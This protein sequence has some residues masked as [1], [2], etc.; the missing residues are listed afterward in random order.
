MVDLLGGQNLSLLIALTIL[1]ILI[2]SQNGKF[3]LPQNLLNIGQN[4]AV[5]GLVATVETVIIVAG[6]LDISVGA[7]AGVASVVC[8]LAVV[9]TG[10]P[11]AGIVAG[12]L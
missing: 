9:N 10:S 4:I 2:G 7:I 8:A 6:C 3:F 1:I 12:T 11:A 5:V